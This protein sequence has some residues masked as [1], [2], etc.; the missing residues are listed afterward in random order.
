MDLKRRE[1]FVVTNSRP[2]ILSF[3]H[4]IQSVVLARS[5]VLHASTVPNGHFLQCRGNE[6]EGRQGRNG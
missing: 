5:C 1:V 4:K 3:H 2:A 6:E